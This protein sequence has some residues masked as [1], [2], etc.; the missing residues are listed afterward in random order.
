[1]KKDFLVCVDSDGCAMDTMNSKH[2]RCFGPCMVREWSLQAWE[3]PILER[4]NQINLT[5]LTRGGNRFQG[6]A[7][8]LR[9]IDEKYLRIEGLHALTRWV[10]NSDELSNTALARAI[11][12]TPSVCL[13]KAW[14]W[15][16]AVNA[17]IRQL[18]P[19]H[20]FPLVE[21]ALR[22][23]HHHADVAIVSSANRDAVTAEWEEHG[24]LEY[25]D[26]ILTQD[27]GS[28]T[29]C[30]AQLLDRGYMAEHVLMCGDAPG[31]R[32]AA[33]TNG[34]YF[35]PILAG[36]EEESWREFMDVGLAR[37]L[38]GDYA[39]YEREKIRTFY[40][41]LGAEGE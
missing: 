21:G 27:S 4:W 30:I 22:Y 32:Q 33:K 36:R 28:K 19:M 24:L 39:A 34:V 41:N 3:K 40:Q 35:Y 38:S 13:K 5:S 6:L 20:P 25:V 17:A 16:E 8:A 15:S 23:A 11:E 26:T 10:E 31:D 18:P 7:M 14:H 12:K 29:A 37:F 9:E 1:M 2:I